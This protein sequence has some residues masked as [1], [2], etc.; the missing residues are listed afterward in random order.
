MKL[1]IR[2]PS[3]ATTVEISED[4]SIQKL[5]DIIAEL[6][7]IVKIQ[8]R[9]GYP[10]KAL[11]LDGV[12]TAAPLSS[13]GVNLDGQQLTIS[14]AESTAHGGR[15][16]TD[17]A[18]SFI[19]QQTEEP[20]RKSD[21]PSVS[22]PARSKQGDLNPPELPVP[23]HESTMV[24]RIMPD[25]NSCLFRAF[26]SAY[27][28]TLDSMTELRSLVAQVI[29]AKPDQYSAAILEQKPDEYCAW[30][31]SEYAWGGGIELSILSQHFDIEVCSIDVQSLRVDRF[32]EGK[33]QRCILVYSGIHYDV[34]ALSPSKAPHRSATAPPEFDQ[35]IFDSADDALLVRALDVCRI[36]NS[37][38]Y[39]TDTAT[40]TVMC[41]IC[42]K[43]L[44]GTKQAQDHRASTGHSRFEEYVE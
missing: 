42:Q 39:F 24:L 30:I 14:P 32:N 23:A 1:R 44:T 27:L 21:S 4:E 18:V 26:G 15:N 29:Q 25:D 40:F 19:R 9:H 36:L 17:K 35:K 8:I 6:T 28:G 16:E 20:L 13:L 38:H 33:T 5:L 31:Q 37:K 10:L 41:S 7:D 3:G 43:P 12:D 22:Q 11:P 34:I 2:G